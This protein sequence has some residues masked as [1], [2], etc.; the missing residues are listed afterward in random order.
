MKIPVQ[1]QPQIQTNGLDQVKQQTLPK[2]KKVVQPLLTKPTTDR[3]IGY[4]SETSIIPGHAI[5]PKI[6]TRQVPFYPDPLIKLPPRLP[7]TQTQDNRRTT[8]D[9][10]RD[11][12][13]DI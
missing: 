13:K 4:M 12:N 2:H 6:N 10:D 9:L 7:D 3:P 11:I 8:L 1:I 5:R